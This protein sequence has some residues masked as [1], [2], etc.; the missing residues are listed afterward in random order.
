MVDV[1]GDRA[2]FFPAIEK[3]HGEPIAKWFERL[4]ELGDAKYP[5]Q[6]AFLRENHGF[7]QAHANAVVMSHRNSPSSKRFKSPAEFFASLEPTAATTATTIFSS[8]TA[9]FPELELVIAWNQPMLRTNGQYVLGLSVAKH[10]ILLNPFSPGVLGQLAAELEAYEVNKH[11]IRV[12]LDWAID[13]ALLRT[14][15]EARLAEL[16]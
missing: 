6:I 7:S 1:S 5:E 9:S 15:A 14:L 16:R 12:P 13:E 11:T 4:A 3:K 8:I 2:R 10:H